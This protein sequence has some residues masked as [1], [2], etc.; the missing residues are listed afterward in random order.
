MFGKI[1]LGG[2]KRVAAAVGALVLVVV[3]TGAAIGATGTGT[4]QEESKAVIDAAA[5]DLG[6]SST[7][8]TEAL[9]QA[10]VA[11]VEAAVTAGRLTEAQATELKAR[12]TSGE[13]P[14]I[15]LGG[16][17]AGPGRIG[18]FGELEAAAT[19]LGM[20]KGELRT[21]LDD[22]ETTLATVAEDNG[23]TADG[24][25]DAMVAAVTKNVNAAVTAGTL[26]DAERDGI[27]ATLEER[28]TERVNSVRPAHA[29]GGHHRFG[30]P[31]R[32]SPDA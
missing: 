11:R 8:L 31:P 19:Y 22:G 28:I 25:V 23:K 9:E 6:V 2:T 29:P 5:T 21:A 13:V 7:E 1:S 27:L 12:I 26:T 18:H 16:H 3:G 24:L 17:R 30:G 14:L 32:E 20:T 4:P 15:G 10:L